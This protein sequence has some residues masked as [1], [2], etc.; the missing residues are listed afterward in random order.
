MSRQATTPLSS[1]GLIIKLQQDD[2]HR[3]SD[4]S[5]LKEHPSGQAQLP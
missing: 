5:R 1:R 3:L 4:D 2:K